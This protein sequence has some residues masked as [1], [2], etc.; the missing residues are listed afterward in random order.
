MCQMPY[1]LNPPFFTNT[2]SNG[3]V[4]K[5]CARA[6]GAGT[7]RKEKPGTGE[8]DL[9]LE[10]LDSSTFPLDFMKQGYPLALMRGANEQRALQL[11]REAERALAGGGDSSGVISAR[12]WLVLEGCDVVPGRQLRKRACRVS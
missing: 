4:G 7:Q 5:H 2:D 6:S 10:T 11:Y 9:E 12:G 8:L 1:A 3:A